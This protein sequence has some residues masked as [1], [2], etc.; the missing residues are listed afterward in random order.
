MVPAASSPERVIDSSAM[1]VKIEVSLM[2]KICREEKYMLCYH[3]TTADNL[4]GILSSG[5]LAN[6]PGRVWHVSENAVYFY[7]PNFLSNLLSEYDEPNDLDEETQHQ[8]FLDQ[9]FDNASCALGKAK[10]CRAVVIVFELD[11]DEEGYEVLNDY[12]CPNMEFANCIYK[13]IPAHKIRKVY[14]SNDLSL[15]KG[16]FLAFR[17]SNPYYLEGLSQFEESVANMWRES[18]Y[19]F[20]PESFL[21]WEEYAEHELPG[22]IKS[23]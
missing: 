14:I 5:L 13:D 17:K 2:G 22:L 20:E 10:D 6:P 7:G 23:Y 11:E 16:Y 3:G 1:R 21:F 15:V 12:S 18:G 8:R 9:A 4:K 19:C